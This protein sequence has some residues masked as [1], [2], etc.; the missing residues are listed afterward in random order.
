MQFVSSRVLPEPCVGLFFSCQGSLATRPD[1]RNRERCEAGV[2]LDPVCLG[3]ADGKRGLEAAPHYALG[4]RHGTDKDG[5]DVG[6]MVSM[7]CASVACCL[8][9]R[10]PSSSLDLFLCSILGWYLGD[11][12][13]PIPLSRWPGSDSCF[14]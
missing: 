14:E 12:P 11:R 10:C 3:W 9:M 2:G 6:E 7:L 8:T 4:R 1:A 5:R 13:P